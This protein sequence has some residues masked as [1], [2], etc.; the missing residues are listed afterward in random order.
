MQDQSEDK[1]PKIPKDTDSVF[2]LVTLKGRIVLG[3]RVG[4][5]LPLELMGSTRGLQKV[6]RYR[7]RVSILIL[8][9]YCIYFSNR[10][11]ISH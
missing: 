3:S 8:V 11:R 10:S 5:G 4:F 7:E 9:C 6:W 2:V 1:T